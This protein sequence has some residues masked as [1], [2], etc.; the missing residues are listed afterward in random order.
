MQESAQRVMAA[1]RQTLEVLRDTDGRQPTLTGYTSYANFLSGL[2][3][4]MSTLRMAAEYQ[5]RA[6]VHPLPVRTEHALYQLCRKTFTN[7]AKHAPGAPVRAGLCF[8]AERIVLE[9]RN[10][11]PAGTAPP[12]LSETLP[13]RATRE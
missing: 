1:F 8:E 10:G 5:L 6:T 12:A 9:V 4:N 7:A 13:A 3:R 2:V 11:P